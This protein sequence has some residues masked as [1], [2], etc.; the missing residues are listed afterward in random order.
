MSPLTKLIVAIG[1]VIALVFIG[2]VVS[3]RIG[4]DV[5]VA[6]SLAVWTIMPR[7]GLE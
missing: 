3:Q 2:V 7:E 5:G 4:V 1:R 6:S